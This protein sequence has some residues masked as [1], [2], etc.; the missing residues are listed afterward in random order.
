MHLVVPAPSDGAIWP[1]GIEEEEVE[2]LG[3]WE[4]GYWMWTVQ[5][6]GFSSWEGVEG[7][8]CWV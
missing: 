5:C 4:C 1:G 3:D 6:E 7:V 2:F 8:G